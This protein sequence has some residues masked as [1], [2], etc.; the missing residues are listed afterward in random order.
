MKMNRGQ[1]IYMFIFLV[2]FLFTFASILLKILDYQRAAL[3]LQP[4]IVIITVA[5]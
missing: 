2:A 1:I 4:F 5:G 3:I